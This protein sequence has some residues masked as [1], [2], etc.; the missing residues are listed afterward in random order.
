MHN[1]S[2]G[3][4]VIN[5]YSLGPARVDETGNKKLAVFTFPAKVFLFTFGG[6]GFWELFPAKD[7]PS[8]VVPAALRDQLGLPLAA[9]TKSG[10]ALCNAP[11]I[12]DGIK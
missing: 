10:T 11:K 8:N 9:C 3:S 6:F 12:T 5:F 7:F 2:T 1:H 4:L